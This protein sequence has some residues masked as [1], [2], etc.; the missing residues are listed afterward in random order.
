MGIFEETGR[1]LLDMIESAGD[2]TILLGK[3]FRQFRH[4]FRERH[5]TRRQAFLYGVCSIPVVTIT[6]LFSGMVIGGQTGFELRKI[7]SGLEQTVGAIVGAAM[8]REMGP[9]LTAV[10]LAGFVGGGMA[11][12]IGTMKVNEEID[13]LTVMSINP[14]RY[15]I[16]PRL[17]AMML[18]V[19]TLTVYADMVGIGG[20]AIVAKY[21]LDV[22]FYTFFDGAF[23]TL[24]IKDVMFGL[25]KGYFFGIIIT[26]ISCQQG[27]STTGGAEGVGRATMRSVVYSF[28]MILIANYLLF[29]LLYRP[30]FGD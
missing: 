16:M 19:P 26:M 2:G 9:V 29:S 1:F 8:C 17:V 6:A 24:R 20:G 25:L 28:L 10:V 4:V 5:K 14:V 15:L 23:R 11:S 12:V 18:V 21:Q 22:S 30:L 27:M 7:A 3:A 13:A